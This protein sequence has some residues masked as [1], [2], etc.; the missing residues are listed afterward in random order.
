MHPAKYMWALRSLIYKPFFKHIGSMTYMGKPCFIEGCKRISIGKKTRIFPGIRMEAIG[1]GEIMIGDNCAIEQNV[2][3]ISHGK[4]L[5]IGDDTTI[6]SNVFISNVD[7]EYQN[8][9]KSVMDQPL[10]EKETHI[11]KGCF[12]GVGASILPGTMLGNHCIVGSN[13]VVK[14]VF[15]DNCVI[16]GI[17]GKVIKNYELEQK[18]WIKEQ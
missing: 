12:I 9:T 6:S 14:G 1:T 3:I 5:E 15:Q 18:Q 10:I 13:S 2:H 8:V 17:P 7:H 16:A 4:R 11:G